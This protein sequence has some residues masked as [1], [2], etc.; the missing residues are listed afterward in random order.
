ML[1]LKQVDWFE[2]LTLRTVP[3]EPQIGWG[4]GA[5]WTGVMVHETKNKSRGSS[6][7]KRRMQ[8]LEMNEQ[9][10]K[11]GGKIGSWQACQMAASV[12]DQRVEDKFNKAWC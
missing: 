6:P 5:G 9:R 1:I 3:R 12:L 8:K 7:V 11:P 4:G 2:D 10:P